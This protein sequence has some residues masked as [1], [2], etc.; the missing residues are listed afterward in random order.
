MA[1]NLNVDSLVSV[2]GRTPKAGEH[3]Q[4]FGILMEEETPIGYVV[5]HPERG[6]YVSEGF[7][8]HDATFSW[9]RPRYFR[10]MDEAR[11]VDYPGCVIFALVLKDMH[12]EEG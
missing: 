8:N 7:R 1:K 12:P 2:V 11:K 6:F 4:R 9:T 10:N 5:M 3:K